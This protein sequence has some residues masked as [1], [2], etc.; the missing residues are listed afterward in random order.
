MYDGDSSRLLGMNKSTTI[1]LPVG[2][3]KECV[4][5]VMY[6]A[7]GYFSSVSF[8]IFFPLWAGSI[9]ITEPYCSFR[10]KLTTQ[11]AHETKKSLSEEDLDMINTM[12]TKKG[13]CYDVGTR[14]W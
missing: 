5:Q 12:E 9:Q 1:R 10:S 13:V 4:F 8:R 6:S 14:T 7:Q 11:A 3:Q 2:I